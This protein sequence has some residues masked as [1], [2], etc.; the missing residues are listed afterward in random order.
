MD[1]DEYKTVKETPAKEMT[2]DETKD[3]S[4]EETFEFKDWAI[5]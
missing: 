3:A 1:K 5:I 2:P 4:K